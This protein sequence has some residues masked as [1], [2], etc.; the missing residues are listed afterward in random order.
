M[1]NKKDNYEQE[2][3]VR[4]LQLI[5]VEKIFSEM[6]ERNTTLENKLHTY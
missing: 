3:N 5:L 1:K 6:E 2:L 4:N